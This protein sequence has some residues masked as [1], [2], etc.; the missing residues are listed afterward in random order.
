MQGHAFL[1]AL[2]AVA[3]ARQE[4]NGL[5]LR[6]GEGAL[7]ITLVRDGRKP[8]TGRVDEAAPTFLDT[9]VGLNRA[10]DA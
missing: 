7:A 3:T 10:S 6:T 4:G 9:N 2:S 5:E 8:S 1:K